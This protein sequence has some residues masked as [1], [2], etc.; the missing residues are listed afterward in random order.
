MIL[1]FMLFLPSHDFCSI[2]STTNKVGVGNIFICHYF[3]YF[4][5]CTCLC[6]LGPN[7]KAWLRV[8]S[9]NGY[10]LSPGHS[11]QP[12]A[13]CLALLFHHSGYARIERNFHTRTIKSS[14]GRRYYLCRFHKGLCTNV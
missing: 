10:V 13:T 6:L 7:L 11:E 8:F 9:G 5:Y 12:L 1:F 2:W 14:K 3:V 4:Y